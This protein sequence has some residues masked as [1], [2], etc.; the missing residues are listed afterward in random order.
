MCL[1][2]KVCLLFEILIVNIDNIKN[3]PSQYFMVHFVKE[4]SEKV[5]PRYNH[6]SK[7]AVYLNLNS[8]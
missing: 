6:C 2:P 8:L 7:F 5:D 1:I 3:C 4:Y